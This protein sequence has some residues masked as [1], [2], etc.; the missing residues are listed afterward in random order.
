MYSAEYRGRHVSILYKILVINTIINHTLKCI[1]LIN[2]TK[3][4]LFIMAHNWN[5]KEYNKYTFPPGKV[6][7]RFH[8][9]NI[10]AM[11][12]HNFEAAAIAKWSKRYW[13]DHSRSPTTM[14]GS[15]FNSGSNQWGLGEKVASAMWSISGFH[16]VLLYRCR[17]FRTQETS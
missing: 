14:R 7:A 11:F 2:I 6:Y 16:W 9:M 12:K 10:Q 13:A 8:F 5:N 17:R 15:W 3:Y 4:L 1:P